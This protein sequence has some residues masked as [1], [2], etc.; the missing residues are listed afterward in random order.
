MAA[1]RA[2]VS[3]GH[4]GALWRSALERVWTFLATRDDLRPAGHNI[5][6][7]HRPRERGEP[8]T[9]EFGVEVAGAFE[10]EGEIEPTS[11][12]SGQAATVRVEAIGDLGMAYTAIEAWFRASGRSP[13]GVS[14]EVYGDPGDDPGTFPIEVFSL[15]A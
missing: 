5:F 14:W 4:V 12:P 1:V 2:R 9:V 3:A 7:Y 13:A 11:T 6:V 15:L 10:G 8:M